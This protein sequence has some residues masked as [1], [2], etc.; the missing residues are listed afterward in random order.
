MC[1]TPRQYPQ[2]SKHQQIMHLL[3]CLHFMCVYFD[4]DLRIENISG[5]ENI[6][7]DNVTFCRWCTQR[8]LNC[9]SYHPSV[10]AVGDVQ[11][12]GSLEPFC[13]LD[14]AYPI[15]ASEWFVD[16]L[17]SAVVYQTYTFL[18]PDWAYLSAVRNLHV[19]NGMGDLMIGRLKFMKGI[20]KKQTEVCRL[21][22]WEL[23]RGVLDRQLHHRDNI[24]PCCL[25]FFC[26]PPLWRVHCAIPISS[27]DPTVHMTAL[28][29]DRSNPSVLLN[30][31]KVSKFDQ[32][33]QGVTLCVGRMS[34][35][36]WQQ[37]S[38]TWRDQ[39]RPI[40]STLFF[41]T[42][43]HWCN[44]IFWSNSGRFGLL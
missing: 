17:Y 9:T 1:A 36:W 13:Q 35:L 8:S 5:S 43:A 19:M 42:L 33:R 3:H 21:Y 6:V 12:V 28:L 14:Q 30:H 26:L 39:P 18:H 44:P 20:Y 15:P 23:I 22:C 37:F 2:S 4:I 7:V 11:T 41:K 29:N 34:S 25:V 27:F 24:T 40:V 10:A 38:F 32:A 31:L 16:L